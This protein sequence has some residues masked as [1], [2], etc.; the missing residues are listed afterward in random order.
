MSAAR[1]RCPGARHHG[2]DR[3]QA[4]RHPEQVHP[5][6]VAVSRERR[7]SGGAVD[8]ARLVDSRD[9]G[10]PRGRPPTWR[11]TVFS[12]PRLRPVAVRLDHGQLVEVHAD[13]RH[14]CPL[15]AAPLHAQATHGCSRQ[16]RAVILGRRETEILNSNLTVRLTSADLER[17]RER[18]SE[19]DRSAA[20]VAR[21][22]I[23]DALAAGHTQ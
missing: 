9:C 10:P 19:E 18:A 23:R 11:P 2:P 22:A 4:D 21:R 7:R 20:S 13:G 15:D 8:P 6:G 16:T 3:A 12:L 5:P 17:L 14:P 1:R